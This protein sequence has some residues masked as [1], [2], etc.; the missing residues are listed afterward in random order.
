MYEIFEDCISENAIKLCFSKAVEEMKS[1]I[2][3]I[4]ELANGYDEDLLFLENAPNENL[5][6]ASSCDR[7]CLLLFFHEFQNN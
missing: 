7:I 5:Q 6:Q 3:A 2:D 4:I 1:K